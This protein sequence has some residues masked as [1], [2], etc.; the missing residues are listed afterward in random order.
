M[1]KQLFALLAAAAALVVIFGFIES[2]RHAEAEA[3]RD[4]IV[5]PS[6]PDEAARRQRLHPLRPFRTQFED[7]AP[8]QTEPLIDF[9]RELWLKNIGS[10]KDGAGMCVASSLE[11]MALY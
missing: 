7:P 11:Q 5:K 1:I 2:A 10:R 4:K 6:G 9:P 3:Q 8:D